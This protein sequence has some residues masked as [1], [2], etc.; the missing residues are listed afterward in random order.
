VSVKTGSPPAYGLAA[1]QAVQADIPD[2]VL[3]DIGLPDIDGYEVCRRIR[4]L[5][6]IKQ[7]VIIA[8][9]GW[10]RD[11]NRKEAA[12]AGFD[13]HLTKPAGPQAVISLLNERIAARS[14][15]AKP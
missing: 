12:A 9:T 14:Q 1:V 6:G 4:T 15:I 8:L 5:K 3:L 13:A 2:A 10:G 11:E 7:P